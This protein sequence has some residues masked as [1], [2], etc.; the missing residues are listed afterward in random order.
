M[1]EKLKSIIFYITL[2]LFII[3]V[4]F[5]TNSADY[6]LFAR[7]LQGQAF[8]NLG[9]ILHHD[10]FSYTPT[11][12][13]YD[14]EWGASVIFY[15]VFNKFGAIGL[16]WLK[17]LIVFGVF[18]FAIETLKI[19]GVKFSTPYNFLFYFLAYHAA[20]FSGFSSTIRCQLFTYLFFVI[21]LYLLERVRIK[22]EHY[23]LVSF[24]PMMLFWSNIHGGCMAGFGLLILYAIGEAINKKPFKYYLFAI[25]ACALITFANPWGLEYVK[26]LLMATTMPRPL[27]GEWQPTFGVQNVGSFM[28]FKTFFI[29]TILL[30]IIRLISKIKTIKNI[31][32]TKALIMLTMTYL[33]L[34]YTRHQPFFVICT[35][36]FLYNDFYKI[37]LAISE[38]LIKSAQIREKIAKIKE[39]SLLIL[40]AF[41]TFGYFA[42]T[43]QQITVSNEKYPIKAIEFIKQNELKG[44]LLVDFHHG[45]YAAYKLFPNNLIAMDGRYEEV[46]PD[47][48]LP[49]FNNFFMQAGKNPNLLIEKFRPDIIIVSHDYKAEKSLETNKTYK[50]VYSDEINSVFIDKNLTKKTYKKPTEDVQ[51]YNE[52]LF[53]SRLKFQK[54]KK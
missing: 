19:R 4:S 5:Q 38:K 21:W 50:K 46:Y 53:D 10:I 30:A 23:L 36:V 41:A 52:T 11:H 16:L 28:L 34:K 43:K 9:N 39:V 20:E 22:K 49:L 3:L 17:A 7:L 6:D 18:F 2:F 40:V 33:S 26:F 25:L 8:W 15:W 24:V 42:T 27:I 54:I 51:Y 32:Y 37:I 29:T 14:H 48:M 1:N 31:D 45:S 35:I 47:Y 12:T 44:N 13:W